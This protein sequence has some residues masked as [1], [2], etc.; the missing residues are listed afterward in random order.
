M[1]LDQLVLRFFNMAK[2][3]NKIIYNIHDEDSWTDAIEM[4]EQ[5][6]VVVDVHQEWCG[7]CDAMMPTFQRVFLEYDDAESRICIASTSIQAL[8]AKIQTAIPRDSNVHLDK[9]GCLPLF[10]ILRYKTCVAAIVGVDAPAILQ[11]ISMNIPEKKDKEED[12]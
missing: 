2:D 1:E 6:V 4:S 3:I 12:R 7:V 10:L 11:Q 9:H 5:K 8:G